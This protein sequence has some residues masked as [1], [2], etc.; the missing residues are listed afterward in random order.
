M[1]QPDSHPRRAV[2]VS[3][4]SLTAMNDGL[5]KQLY[6]SPITFFRERASLRIVAVSES[7]EMRERAH[8]YARSI[9]LLS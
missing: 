9:S 7:S 1:E 8:K 2:R 4:L 5:R 6:L 3:E